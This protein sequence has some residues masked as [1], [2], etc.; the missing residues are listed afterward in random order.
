M[1]C[2]AMAHSPKFIPSSTLPKHCSPHEFITK[3]KPDLSHLRVWGVRCF[4]WVPL[5]LQTKL[6]AH[7]REC[8]FMV[9]PE[10]V[11]GYRVRDRVS[12]A[13]FNSRDVI[14]DESGFNRLGPVPDVDSDTPPVAAKPAP[15]AVSSDPSEPSP[16]PASILPLA[17]T[18]PLAP[19]LPP[20]P[21]PPAPALKSANL[22][23]RE[24]SS[25][26]RTLTSRGEGVAAEVA[27][28]AARHE[29]LAAARQSRAM[30]SGNDVSVHIFDDDHA[31]LVCTESA[32]LSI[33]S[34]R[35]RNPASSSYDLKIPPSTYSE[36]KRRPDFEVWEA[37]VVKELNTL[38]SM[39]VYKLTPLP[40]GRKAIGNCWVFE[41]KVDGDSLIPNGQLVAKG[42]HQI[43]NVDFGKTFAPVAKA[44]SI[45]LVAAMACQRGWFLQCFDATRA[46]LWGDLEEELYMSLPEGFRLPTPD[47]LPSGYEDEVGLVMHLF[48]SIYGLKQASNV[49]YKKLRGVLERL[50]MRRSEVDHALFSF[51]GE[52]KGNEVRCLIAIHVDDGIGSSNSLAFLEW[53]KSEIPQE[54]GLKDLVDVTQFL[55]VQFVRNLETRELWMHRKDYVRSLLADYNLLDCNPVA[56]PM[57]S[58]CNLSQ[59]G[60]P[61]TI[62][63]EYQALMG[64]LLFLSI[65]TRLDISYTVNRLTQHNSE[66]RADHLAAAKR[67]LRY[68]RG[69]VDLCLHYKATDAP[70]SLAAYSD[71]DWAGLQDRISVSGHCWFYGDCLIDWGSKKQ[72][73]IALSSTEAEYMALTLCLQ[74]GLWLRSSLLQ[75]SLPFELPIGIAGNNKGS[76][77]LAS[78]SS[79]HSRS[80][81]IDIKY[82]FIREHVDAGTFL[83]SWI[84]TA[85]NVA[86]I[87]TKPLRHN[88][89][90]VHVLGLHVV[91]H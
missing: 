66:P 1:P 15:P 67:V 54:F 6:G 52:W 35:P 48:K 33:R 57:E 56:T 7:S 71:S 75:L 78:N 84:L 30:A 28:S 80:K 86:D 81:H 41:L 88:L 73:M 10:G 62:R 16:P 4:A 12:G 17:P 5:E 27:D 32:F 24:P 45:R 70:L 37:T 76:I 64:H 82:H 77:S 9:Y 19:A 55:G 3:G 20:N 44:A 65:C 85:S 25:R 2:E 47:V 36:A 11:K 59:S 91:P 69:T 40:P 72:R 21:V 8:V 38:H 22:P 50:S 53:I 46:F 74:T 29:R 34:D 60:P 83:I 31:N 63:A 79:H 68:L 49:W 43:P 61:S 87:F 14:F 89:H 23:P 18:A 13:F 90:E 51:S 42:F 58:P 26:I 39:G